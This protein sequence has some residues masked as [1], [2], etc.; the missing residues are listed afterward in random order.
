MAIKNAGNFKFSVFKSAPREKTHHPSSDTPNRNH[1]TAALSRANLAALRFSMAKFASLR[2]GRLC[3]SPTLGQR[4]M[5]SGG[6]AL[7]LRGAPFLF[8]PRRFVPNED[9]LQETREIDL[10]ETES[11]ER[12]LRKVTASDSARV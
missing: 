7:D 2:S 1:G 6:A 12:S 3:I 9:F 8:R 11:E 4:K 10:A 5:M